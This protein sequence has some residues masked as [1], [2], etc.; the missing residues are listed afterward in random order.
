MS[1]IF[2]YLDWRSDISLA[3][4]PFNEV[5]NLV[6]SELAYAPLE[7]VLDSEE[8]ELSIEEVSRRFFTLHTV[9]EIEGQKGYTACTP[10]LLLKMAGT[11]RFGGTRLF[12]CVDI[13]DVGKTEQMAAVSFIL[14]DHTVYCAFRGTDSSI[15][16]WKEDFNLSYL[17]GTPGQIASAEYLNRH[18]SRTRRQLRVGGHSKGGN[19]AVF[20]AMSADEKVRRKITEVYSNDGPGF[21]SEVIHSDAYRSMLPKIISIVPESSMIGMCLENRYRHI[22]VESTNKN[23]EQHD[24]LSWQVKGSHFVEKSERSPESLFFDNTIR[25]WIEGISDED[26]RRFIDSLFSFY[27]ATGK[28]TVDEVKEMNLVASIRNVV[29]NLRNMDKEDRKQFFAILMKLVRSANIVLTGEEQKG[30]RKLMQN[31][32]LPL[33]GRKDSGAE[34]ES[35]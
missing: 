30:L 25:L 21:R 26:R 34:P 33:P 8:K 27:E 14:P 23:I 29:S 31:F 13:L 17:N 35:V 9:E 11:R 15:A 16:G 18:F 4:D 10:L 5:D 32:E 28:D 22:I 20:A 3:Y 6:L 1:N 12:G 24:G 19:F 2:D 7:E